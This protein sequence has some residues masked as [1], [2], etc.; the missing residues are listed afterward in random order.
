LNIKLELAKWGIAHR[1]AVTAAV[2]VAVVA[3]QPLGALVERCQSRKRKCT[4]DTPTK[5]MCNRGIQ[6]VEGELLFSINRNN[7]CSSVEQSL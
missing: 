6:G 4:G 5:H 7:S 2:A 1:V 3:Y